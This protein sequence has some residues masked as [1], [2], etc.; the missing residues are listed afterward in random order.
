MNTLSRSVRRLGGLVAAAIMVG[1][2]VAPPPA[3]TGV[4]TLSV[5][6]VAGSLG[7]VWDLAFT[8]D[9]TLLFTER[10]G[11][12]NAIVGGA[13]R[14]LGTPADLVAQDEGG[15]LGLAV[16]PAFASNRRIYAC[17]MSNASGP[18]DMRVARFSINAG[19]TA[20][21]SRADLVTGIPVNTTGKTGRHS[22]CRVRIGPDGNVW[23]TT[24]DT[25]TGSVPQ[26]PTSLGGKVLRVTTDGAPAAGNPSG[27]LDPRIYTLGHRN[28]QGLAFRPGSGQAFSVEHGTT[29]DDE[30]NKLVAGGNYGW[31]PVVSGGG[32]DE[33]R[34]M[35]DLER[36]PSALAATWSSGCPTIAPS[37]ATFLTGSKWRDWNGALAMAVLKGSQVRVLRLNTAG[38]SVIKSWTAVTDRGRLRSAVQGPDG[39]LYLATDSTPGSILRVTPS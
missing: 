34:P 21:T 6:T 15:M 3:P 32:Y 1:G 16:D 7:R 35:T 39:N 12:I 19:Y 14:T 37:G 4:P 29:C 2:C 5:S 38:T 30:V 18:L 22:G 27:P 31:D 24:G 36:V 33:S 28:P 25:A 8:P 11:S 26:N 9:N 20:L 13:K 23:I 10:A 17:F